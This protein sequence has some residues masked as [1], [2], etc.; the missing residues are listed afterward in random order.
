MILMLGSYTALGLS[1]VWH[2]TDLWRAGGPIDVLRADSPPLGHELTGLTYGYVAFVLLPLI[3][4]LLFT[5][6]RWHILPLL[7]ALRHDVVLRLDARG[8][9]DKRLGLGFIPWSAVRRL[10][11]CKDVIE[12]TVD[13]QAMPPVRGGFW[14]PRKP[15]IL[16]TPL[17]V[18]SRD[19][20]KEMEARRRGAS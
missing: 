1:L 16:V 20:I 12:V 18:H 13:W 5:L 19:L 9:L 7:R 6:I 8:F 15:Q 2:A 14:R 3:L 10:R 17:Q 4:P 11:D